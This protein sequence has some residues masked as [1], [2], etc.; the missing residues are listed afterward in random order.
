MPISLSDAY[1]SFASSRSIL[2]CYS[3]SLS[4]HLF[5][6]SFYSLGISLLVISLLTPY[7]TPDLTPYLTPF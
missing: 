7:L 5:I 1:L 4:S 3:H 6:L 2:S